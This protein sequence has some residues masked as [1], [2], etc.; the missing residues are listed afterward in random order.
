MP[1]KSPH[2]VPLI[3]ERDRELVRA[4]LLD[5]VESYARAWSPGEKGPGMAFAEIV[6]FLNGILIERLN[7]FAKKAFLGT[8]DLVG[9]A[10][11]PRLAARAMLSFTPVAGIPDEGSWI[12]AGTQVA[13]EEEDA[14][15]A[16]IVFETARDVR[17]SRRSIVG[18]F[19]RFG[20]DY[21]DHSAD[22]RDGR[23]FTLFDNLEP[24]RSRLLLSDE[25]FAVLLGE[26]QVDVF[27]ELTDCDA[28]DD[29]AERL[30]WSFWDGEQWLDLSVQTLPTL[31][32]PL[33]TRVGFRI[34]G[35]LPVAEGLEWPL[36]TLCNHSGLWLRVELD[37]PLTADEQKLSHCASVRLRLEA[38]EEGI[39]PDAGASFHPQNG[40]S[41]LFF[42]EGVKPFGDVPAFDHAFYLTAEEAFG[43]AEARV[44]I[45]FS[46]TG[47]DERPAS[48]PSPDLI[49]KWE[50][51]DGEEWA[52]L[53]TSTPYGVHGASPDL[54]FYD[55]TQGFYW[56]GTVGFERPAT[57][58]PTSV[59]GLR[60]HWL[61]CRIHSGDYGK[62]E[63][64][65]IGP[66][67]V[68]WRS[69]QPVAPPQI[70]RVVVRYSGALSDPE[71]VRG[72][73]DFAYFE[74]AEILKEKSRFALFP[75]P[76]SEPPLACFGLDALPPAGTFSIDFELD[77]PPHGAPR[78]SG[79]AAWEYW[80]GRRWA[81]LRPLD[82]TYGLSRSEVL[83]FKTPPDWEA[84]APYGVEGHWLRARFPG[85]EGQ[86]IARP[87]I[88]S[89]RLN[90][91]PGLEGTS[92][93]GER[94]GRSTGRARMEFPFSNGPLT[95]EVVLAVEE[96][97]RL[98]EHERAALRAVH[99]SDAVWEADGVQ[100]ARWVEV[101]HFADSRP[102]DRH[103]V[104]DRIEGLVGFGDGRRGLI[105][106]RGAAI[107]A[108]SYRVGGGERG[109]LEAGA[110]NILRVSVP[111][112]ESVRNAAPAR[113]GADLQPLDEI[114]V[115]GPELLR[116]RNRAMASDDYEVLIERTFPQVARALC[117]TEDLEDGVVK[118]F[119][120]PVPDTGE[121]A[122]GP[123]VPSPDL[124]AAVET[125]L[126]SIC[127]PSVKVAVGAPTY[128]PISIRLA[129]V[130]RAG[131]AASERLKSRLEGE[132]RR[133]L[134]PVQG[135][136]GRGWPWGRGLAAA[137]LN[138]VLRGIGDVERLT[139]IELVD[140]GR[141][142]TVARRTL[143]E[144]E[145]FEVISVQAREE[146]R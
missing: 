13:T 132:V 55:S 108:E 88:A 26:A 19:S 74:P 14:S 128:I 115:Q 117:V 143:K 44:Q 11:R 125:Y 5:L 8:L 1:A 68:D 81:D 30:L 40:Y 139:D 20:R 145:L 129:F 36:L 29:F 27:L 73:C 75:R 97:A 41:G 135:A 17:V 104:V 116:N 114:L 43:R 23:S 22:A 77:D 34:Q 144:R 131:G 3:D 107:V 67:G 78:A 25:R 134:D 89:V 38:P 71:L 111:Y 60:A 72:Q 86:K 51:Y 64:L 9:L 57:W 121:E 142:R 109:N 96:P 76:E 18:V 4:E 137:E 46:L 85:S 110:L 35:P 33:G 93:R 59:R 94:L 82:L 7:A 87:V 10:L 61:R 70:S 6:A 95:G 21:A 56:S 2:P 16:P 90:S 113:G 69:S 130:S 112:V 80:N 91:A 105:P 62:P 123:P 37:K 50:Y 136:D 58:A 53:G 39:Q 140:E 122:S 15:G 83:S 54:Y 98:L 32:G 124:R 49:L 66:D 63:A 28:V 31:D 101:P 103:F 126:R 133:F 102:R 127:C 92:I 146:P 52:E 100:W 84:S 138:Q 106:H 48:L 24:L 118:V 42:A 120:V 79:S 119:L 65:V 99:G 141:R 12:P 47:S 45:D